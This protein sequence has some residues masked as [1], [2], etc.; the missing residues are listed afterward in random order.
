V[1]VGYD[2][3]RERLRSFIEVGMSKFVV[4]PMSVN[5]SWREELTG[6]AEG[7]VVADEGP[8]EHGDGAV[9]EGLCVPGP[10]DGPRVWAGDV[11]G[12]DGR[13]YVAVAVGLDPAVP[14]FIGPLWSLIETHYRP[15]RQVTGR[16]AKHE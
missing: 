11:S 15:G 1:P 5:G 2:A 6:L 9:G 12:E 3:L 10:S 4:R 7:L 16:I 8:G 13:A 14:F